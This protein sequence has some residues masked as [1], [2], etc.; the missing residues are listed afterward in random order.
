MDN[1][2]GYD[3]SVADELLRESRMGASDPMRLI[4][5][6]GEPFFLEVVWRESPNQNR[7]LPVL[8][9]FVSKSG[10]APSKRLALKIHLTLWGMDTPH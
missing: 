9:E 4:P 5:I 7:D 10:F 8:K 3:L 1:R 6:S 2:L